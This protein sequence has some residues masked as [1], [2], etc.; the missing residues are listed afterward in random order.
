MSGFKGCRESL[1]LTRSQLSRMAEV[2]IAYL[3]LLEGGLE[4]KIPSEAKERM[5]EALDTLLLKRKINKLREE[6]SN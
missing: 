5:I 1:G 2:E 4:D 6:S 3:Y